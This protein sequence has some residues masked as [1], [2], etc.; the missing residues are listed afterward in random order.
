MEWISEIDRRHTTEYSIN[1]PLPFSPTPNNMSHDTDIT[2]LE[3]TVMNSD[4]EREEYSNLDD[5]PIS[6]TEGEGTTTEGNGLDNLPTTV[7]DTVISKPFVL[8]TSDADDARYREQQVRLLVV[9]TG[10]ERALHQQKF[11]QEEIDL[12]RLGTILNDLN[13]D[14]GSGPDRRVPPTVT[15]DNGEPTKLRFKRRSELDAQDHNIRDSDCRHLPTLPVNK[16]KGSVVVEVPPLST[17]QAG[18]ET[19]VFSRQYQWNRN[20]THTTKS[21]FNP[22]SM[23]GPRLHL[24]GHNWISSRATRKTATC[25]V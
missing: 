11:D 25:L 18:H 14:T 2:S 22:F 10:I 20:D 12:K 21:Y 19:D 15:P 7:T 9:Q 5:H 6:D 13:R 4:D 24:I 23:F 8:D 1:P 3:Q 17:Q 16:G